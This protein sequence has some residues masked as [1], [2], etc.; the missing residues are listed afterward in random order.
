[1]PSAASRAILRPMPKRPR[2]TQQTPDLFAAA[3]PRKEPLDRV[4]PRSET[5]AAPPYIL[6]RDLSAS[7]AHL[8]DEHLETLAKAVTQELKR[9]K[10]PVLS[11]AALVKEMKPKPKPK[12]KPS[13]APPSKR[14]NRKAV[15][16]AEMAP[17]TQ[18]RINVILA[19]FKAGVKPST[20]SRQFGISQ[21]TVRQVLATEA[22]GR[23][24]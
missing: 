12:P 5:A 19:A 9:R 1:M 4:S 15:A 7:L 6:P 2:Y 21:A 8:S 11:E 23:K 10:L 17:L 16:E 13:A 24:P 22:R 20:I 18:S 3:T 14:S